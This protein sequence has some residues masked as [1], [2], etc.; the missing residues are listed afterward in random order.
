LINVK[1]TKGDEVTMAA[2]PINRTVDT[3]KSLPPPP[4]LGEHTAKIVKEFEM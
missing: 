3:D 2:P 1:T 4:K